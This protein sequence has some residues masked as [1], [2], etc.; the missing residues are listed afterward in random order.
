MRC[1]FR[2]HT[3]YIIRSSF[4]IL[5][6]NI[7]EDCC[8]KEVQFILEAAPQHQISNDAYFFI[9]KASLVSVPNK[10]KNGSS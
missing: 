6:H 1:L 3:E 10:L 9:L 5:V 7:C 8:V 4:A 2:C